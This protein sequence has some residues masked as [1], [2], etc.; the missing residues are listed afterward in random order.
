M[1]GSKAR[2]VSSTMPIPSNMFQNAQ[3]NPR[4]SALRRSQGQVKTAIVMAALSVD[5][6][7]ARSLLRQHDGNL[8]QLLIQGAAGPAA[9]PSHA[10]SR[11]RSLSRAV[12]S[13]RM[14]T[15]APRHPLPS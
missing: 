6:S 1:A 4:S 11:R 7:T 9:A 13:G 10:S 3:E 8:S 12:R 2:V 5:A 15:L 14:G